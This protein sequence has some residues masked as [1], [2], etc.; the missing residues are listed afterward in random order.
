MMFKSRGKKE[1]FFK[2]DDLIGSITNLKG[3][4]GKSYL[5]QVKV[6][7]EIWNSSLNTKLEVGEK[8]KIINQND[9]QMKVSIETI[10]R[11]N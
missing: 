7:G 8:V 10:S 4:D 1:T 3:M 6:N 2:N 9:N 5:Y 11:R